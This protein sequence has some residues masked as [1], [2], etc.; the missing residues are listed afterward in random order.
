MSTHRDDQTGDGCTTEESG[1]SLFDRLRVAGW[2]SNHRTKTYLTLNPA[3][4]AV[5][6]GLVDE[7]GSTD[8]AVRADGGPGQDDSPREPDAESETLNGG[9][10]DDGGDGDRSPFDVGKG[11][12]FRQKIG[13]VLGPLLFALIMLAP[14]PDTK[15]R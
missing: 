9:D 2:R 12:G 10:G 1:R 14:T 8:R 13:F 4:I 6:L 7:R 3:G 11:Y 5:D 15:R